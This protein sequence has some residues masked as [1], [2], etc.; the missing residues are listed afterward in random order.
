M[1]DPAALLAA[2]CDDPDDIVARLAYA[3][4]LEEQGDR[5]A[6]PPSGPSS[7]ACR[8]PWAARTSK[9]LPLRPQVERERELRKRLNPQLK[10]EAGSVGRDAVYRNGFIEGLTLSIDDFLQHGKKLF[11]RIPLRRVCFQ[12]NYQSKAGVAELLASPHLGRLRGVALRGYVNERSEARQLMSCPHL[13]RM[14]SLELWVGEIGVP[15]A[16]LLA[17]SPHL[18]GLRTLH[19]NA[20][21]GD[22]GLAILADSPGLAGVEELYLHGDRF[23]SAGVRAV[24]GSPHFARLRRLMLTAHPGAAGIEAL[25]T[26]PHLTGLERLVLRYASLSVDDARGFQAASRPANLRWLDLSGSF[27]GDS[28]LGDGGAAALAAP[29]LANLRVLHLG[30][31]GIGPEGV[32]ALASTAHFANLHSLGLGYNRIGSEGRALAGGIASSGRA[33]VAAAA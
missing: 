18:T 3:D 10:Q 22:E 28:L 8:S 30:N 17:E 5:P 15:V 27:R 33:A 4:W 24:A 2:I 9:T 12:R 13:A 25:V 31:L 16:P 6:T 26:S 20:R 32:R 14:D 1:H 7:S 19:L 29:Y 23:T 11:A 21:I